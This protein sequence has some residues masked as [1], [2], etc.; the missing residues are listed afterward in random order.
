MN[1]EYLQTI[2]MCIIA[3]ALCFIAGSRVGRG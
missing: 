3:I 1:A 2:A